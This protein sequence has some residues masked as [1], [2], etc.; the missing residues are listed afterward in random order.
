MEWARERPRERDR[1]K[2]DREK[3]DSERGDLTSS[4]FLLRVVGAPAFAGGHPDTNL[5]YAH[6]LVDEMKKGA[7]DLGAA[8]D[9]V[10]DRNMI[11]GKNAFFVT[12]SDSVAVIA[13]NADCIPYLKRDGLK[14]TEA[15]VHVAGAWPGVLPR[16]VP[17]LFSR[18]ASA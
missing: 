7:V 8:F 14:V 5:T 2:R 6:D 4:I 12:P 17:V 18:W 9:G 16:D 1:E 11:L 15:A 3:R 13:A 10:A